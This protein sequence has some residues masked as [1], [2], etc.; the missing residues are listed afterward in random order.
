MRRQPQKKKVSAKKRA[1]RVPA[2]SI[3][4]PTRKSSPRK[5]ISEPV[6]SPAVE[7]TAPRIVQEDRRL[8]THYGEDR[9]VLLVRD[10][11]WIFAYW[12]VTP[13]RQ[14]QVLRQTEGKRYKTVLRVYDVSG[15]S[16]PKSNSFFDI[17]I[18]FHA[19]NW[20]VDVGMPDREWAAEI[21]FRTEDGRFFALVRSNTVRTPAFGISDVLDEEWMLPEDVYF[22]L[23][24]QSFGAGSPG[25]SMDIRRMLEKYLKNVVSSERPAQ[26][27]KKTS[28]A[29][30]G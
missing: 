4:K 30:P 16:L 27:A 13:E 10:P 15:V 24:G 8:P 17:E 20:Y 21:G 19:D 25:G 26:P 9:L 12:E 14:Q 1:L 23:L 6:L 29:N 5:R 18:N 11:W 28:G 22:R 2:R 7:S 3:R